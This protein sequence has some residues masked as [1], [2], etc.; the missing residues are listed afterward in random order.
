VNGLYTF[1]CFV[2]IEI[3]NVFLSDVDPTP[4]AKEEDNDAHPEVSI[5]EE[6]DVAKKMSLKITESKPKV[7]DTQ[8]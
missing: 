2:V 4:I 6:N 8:S 5:P 3:V 1:N 7:C